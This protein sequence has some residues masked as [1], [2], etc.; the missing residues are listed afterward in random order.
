MSK[1]KNGGDEFQMARNPKK[2]GWFDGTKYIPFKEMSNHHLQTAKLHAQRKELI[3]WNT[4]SNFAK[5]AE[6]LD[7]EA[8]RRG[9]ELRDYN[10]EYHKNTRKLKDSIKNDGNSKIPRG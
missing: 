8:A 4:A 7:K 9:L 1:R 3:Y 10:T 6:K 2:E 5:L